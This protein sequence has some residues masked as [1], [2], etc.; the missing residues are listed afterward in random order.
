M[1][2]YQPWFLVAC[3]IGL[4]S[5]KTHPFQPPF[6]SLFSPFLF[7]ENAK[8]ETN[9]A[10]FWKSL[11]ALKAPKQN[12]WC[13]FKS[14]SILLYKCSFPSAFWDLFAAN[15]PVRCIRGFGGYEDAM[16][17]GPQFQISWKADKE[18]LFEGTWFSG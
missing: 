1:L 12:C 4:T 15:R 18:V 7:F 14:I 2:L 13:F 3:K 9:L 11:N 17:V 16:P 8:K 6:T 5:P 10:N